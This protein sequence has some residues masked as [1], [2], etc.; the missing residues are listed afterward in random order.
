MVPFGIQEA[1]IVLAVVLLL[2][3]GKKLP[4]LA[5]GLGEG[6]RGFGDA[7]RGL[8]EAGAGGPEALPATP[9]EAQ[10]IRYVAVLCHPCR[11]Y[12]SQAA[13]QLEGFRT[14][15]MLP[16]GTLLRE[17]RDAHTLRTILATESIGLERATRVWMWQLRE[18]TTIER[19]ACAHALAVS[20][21]EL[22]V[23]ALLQLL[24]GAPPDVYLAAVAALARL[25]AK[26]ITPV[27]TALAV[28]PTSAPVRFNPDV[29]L[30]LPGSSWPLAPLLRAYWRH[31][32]QCDQNSPNAL[33]RYFA[34]DALHEQGESVL[35]SAVAAI[36][37]PVPSP[38]P[39]ARDP[40]LFEALAVA[41]SRWMEGT[42]TGT[43]HRAIDGLLAQG[44]RRS[45]ALLEWM[46]RPLRW[47]WLDPGIVSHT[48][49]AA[50]DLQER[51]REANTAVVPSAGPAGDGTEVAPAGVGA[52]GRGER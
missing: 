22:A 9:E 12:R 45:L 44:D 17:V 29:P 36:T 16:T 4:A 21:W 40:R 42:A 2:V 3:G 47:V 18:G 37:H 8:L 43:A 33:P 11:V 50:R 26:E 7:P 39:C 51:L 24:E 34:R 30:S 19:A 15:E 41:L 32:R 38:L 25:G 27:L 23:P 14:A 46:G 28:E 48:R 35:A 10:F 20:E 6:L 5:K 31:H 52:D 49:S 1:L 13:L